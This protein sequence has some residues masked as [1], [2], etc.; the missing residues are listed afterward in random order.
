MQGLNSRNEAQE[1]GANIQGLCAEGATSKPVFA[2][3]LHAAHPQGFER[4]KARV[5]MYNS[6]HVFLSPFLGA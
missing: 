4:R 1:V 3:S 5:L 2:D 6:P